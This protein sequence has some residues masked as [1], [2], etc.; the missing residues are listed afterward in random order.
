MAHTVITQV[1]LGLFLL[2]GG[3][4]QHLAELKQ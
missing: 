1:D 3:F 2:V 4:E